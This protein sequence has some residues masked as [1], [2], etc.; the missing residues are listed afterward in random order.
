MRFRVFRG[1]RDL[2]SV[3]Q[4]I[5]AF[6][7][8]S[9]F[10]KSLAKVID[11]AAPGCNKSSL[12]ACDNHFIIKH[13]LCKWGAPGVSLWRIEWLPLDGSSGW[14]GKPLLVSFSADGAVFCVLWAEDLEKTTAERIF[15]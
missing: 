11:K 3:F 15:L 13:L 9:L 5:A 4:K 14:K 6:L 1:P 12:I 2:K 10:L 8:C 7:V